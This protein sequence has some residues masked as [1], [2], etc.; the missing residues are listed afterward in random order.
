[1]IPYP[2]CEIL[3]MQGISLSGPDV[4]TVTSVSFSSLNLFFDNSVMYVMHIDYSPP[5][6]SSK[7]LFMPVFLTNLFLT[8]WSISLVWIFHS[9]IVE[10]LQYG[11]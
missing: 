2:F 10:I 8:L 1:M 3:S 7:S 6:S 9:I 5:P 4:L 11:F